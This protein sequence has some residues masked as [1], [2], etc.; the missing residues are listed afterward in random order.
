MDFIKIIMA[1]AE[2][3]WS[4]APSPVSPPATTTREPQQ[5]EGEGWHTVHMVTTPFQFTNW[6]NETKIFVILY[7]LVH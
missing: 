7:G 1:S 5:N 4:S 6:D 2:P 3:S